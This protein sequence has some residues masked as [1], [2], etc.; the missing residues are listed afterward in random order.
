M[1]NYAFDIHN[2]KNKYKQDLLEKMCHAR[3]EARN[4]F[5]LV[6]KACDNVDNWY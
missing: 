3:S 1:I 6:V 4:I 2:M 5:L